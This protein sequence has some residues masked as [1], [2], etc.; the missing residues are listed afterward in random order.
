MINKRIHITKYTQTTTL[1]LSLSS[2]FN[3]Q[4][5]DAIKAII[6]RFFKT[7]SDKRLSIDK[8]PTDLTSEATLVR[9]FTQLLQAFG[10]GGRGA[11]RPVPPTF[12]Y[13]KHFVLKLTLKKSDLS[14]SFPHLFSEHVKTE[15]ELK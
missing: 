4:N 14:R 13:S 15:I 12:S 7:I 3:Y 2:S 1:F 11:K 5:Y 6:I 8:L 10:I 9:V